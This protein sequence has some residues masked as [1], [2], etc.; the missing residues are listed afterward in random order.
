LADAEIALVWRF[1]SEW[2]ERAPRLRVLATPAAGKEDLPPAPPPGV[3]VHFGSYHGKIM[4]ETVVGMMLASCR[5][6]LL[7][8]SLQKEHAWPRVEVAKALVPIRDSHALIVG[9]GAIGTHIVRLLK[10]FGVRVTG[11][12]RTPMEKPAILGEADRLLTMDQLDDELPGADHLILVLPKSPETNLLLDKRRLSLLPKHAFVHNVGRGNS[13][14]EDALTDAL[15]RGDI[16]GACLDVFQQE[17]LPE[18]A[19]IRQAP[20][21]L[22]LPHV[23]AVADVYL[24]YFVEE[25]AEWIQAEKLGA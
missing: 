23:S 5:G 21:L 10:P 12:R 25:L 16:A 15:E 1:K 19:R 7:C 13:V 22:I 14:D 6:L 2:F 18:N 4:A 20:R 24:D 11:F 8:H 9:F 17:P 3:R